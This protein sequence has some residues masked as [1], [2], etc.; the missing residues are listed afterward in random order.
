MKKILIAA[1]M[2]IMLNTN[3]YA[4]IENVKVVSDDNSS[5]TVYAGVMPSVDI[6]D[7]ADVN[8]NGNSDELININVLGQ[9]N[10]LAKF[11]I[12]EYKKGAL[13]VE[14]PIT[15]TVPKGITITGIQ[16]EGG[17]VVYDGKDYKKTQE[18]Y[19]I[20][21]NEFELKSSKFF[22]RVV[23]FNDNSVTIM[24]GQRVGNEDLIDMRIS[25]FVTAPY[26]YS[27]QVDVVVSGEGVGLISEPVYIGEI[28]KTVDIS[29]SLSEVDKGKAT[30]EDIVI[31]EVVG[32]SFKTGETVTVE[33]SNGATFAEM[34]SVA[35]TGGTLKANKKLSN[36][37]KSVQITFSGSSSSKDKGTVTVSNVKIDTSNVAVDE[38]VD[39]IIKSNHVISNPAELAYALVKSDGNNQVVEPI[40]DTEDTENKNDVVNNNTS[41][42]KFNKNV[43]FTVGEKS[44]SVDGK[45]RNISHAPYISKKSG[46]TMIPLRALAEALGIPNEHILWYQPTK[47]ATIIVDDNNVAQFSIG[48]SI[49]YINANSVPMASA[50][51]IV[52]V[53]E[54]KDGAVFLPMRFLSEVVFKVPV[55]WDKAR[56]KEIVFN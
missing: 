15:F 6:K 19:G 45:V 55:G 37:K 26:D 51:G 1:S 56:P 12:V 35:V 38:V 43:V 13:D 11:D 3:V 40:K 29:T 47:T 41:K 34:P 14:K 17:K 5:S 10:K 8:K 7:T 30:A 31:N 53:V 23:K 46:S 50:S 39:V 27:G 25:L 33:L 42:N 52:D 36:D 28:V 54:Y 16:V 24:D 22:D 32:G 18:E 21:E 44:V 2:A 49:C 9:F 48:S 4:N 20:K